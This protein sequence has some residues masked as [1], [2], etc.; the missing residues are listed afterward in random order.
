MGIMY[1]KLLFYVLCS[2][3]LCVIFRKYVPACFKDHVDFL[4]N[5]NMI[6]VHV[7]T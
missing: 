2:K 4:Q 1:V 7:Y 6:K 5:N 3:D